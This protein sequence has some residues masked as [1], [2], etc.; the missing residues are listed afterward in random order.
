MN[1]EQT[2]DELTE[3]E[4]EDMKRD[5]VTPEE[6]HR[7]GEFE[8][9]IQRLDSLDASTSRIMDSVESLRAVLAGIAVDNGAEYTND[10]AED[11]TPPIAII[12][13]VDDMDLDL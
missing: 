8:E 10:G 6:A 7:V 12:P 4:R 11:D 1:D 9:I 13:E 2:R 3:E 5:D